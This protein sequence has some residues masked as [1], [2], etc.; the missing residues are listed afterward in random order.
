MDFKSDYLG[1]WVKDDEY[2]KAQLLWLWYDYHT[3]I[4]DRSLWGT[5]PSR[6][7]E[8]MVVFRSYESQSLAS[9]N[10][11]EIRRKIYNIAKYYNISNET[12][13]NTKNDSFRGR[14]KI[15]VR[16][17]MYEEY[18]KQGKFSFIHNPE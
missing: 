8:T 1:I 15:Q 9:K 6:H 11:A 3:E 17:D 7:D 12:M 4:Y 2:D 14:M 10:A 18:N 5:A 16:L 13:M